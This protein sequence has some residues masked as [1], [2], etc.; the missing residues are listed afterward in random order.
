MTLEFTGP[1]FRW[2]GPAPFFFIAVPPDRCPALKEAARF[3]TYG[4]GMVPVRA[5][6]GGTEWKTSLFPKDGGYLVPVKD[7]VRRAEGLAEG[8]EVGIELHVDA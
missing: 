3:V 2:V 5:R 7:R 4:W 6:I 8:D 1:L